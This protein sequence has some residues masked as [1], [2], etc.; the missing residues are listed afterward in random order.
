[1]SER[2]LCLE[3]EIKEGEIIAKRCGDL[4]LAATKIQGVPFV[5]EDHCP[6][7]GAPLSEGTIDEQTVVCPWHAGIFCLKTGKV[8]ASP[9]LKGIK[10]YS[11]F[12]KEERVY[13]NLA[14]GSP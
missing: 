11:V 14:A 10:T 7:A 6:H 12:V 13:L 5:F 9:P 3:S 8:L 4:M 1:M 2:F